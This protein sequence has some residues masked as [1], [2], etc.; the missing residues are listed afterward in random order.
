ML[1]MAFSTMTCSVKAYTDCYYVQIYMCNVDITESCLASSAY[2][3]ETFIRH[4]ALIFVFHHKRTFVGF[5]S[6]YIVEF[7]YLRFGNAL[8]LIC[9]INGNVLAV[10]AFQSI[11]HSFICN[12]IKSKQIQ[13]IPCRHQDTKRLLSHSLP[14]LLN[15]NMFDFDLLTIKKFVSKVRYE[16]IKLGLSEKNNFIF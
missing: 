4:Q 2:L 5:V 10:I 7:K 16:F 13:L 11:I 1:T 15:R 3:S 14:A 9:Q 8:S 12:Y 6:V